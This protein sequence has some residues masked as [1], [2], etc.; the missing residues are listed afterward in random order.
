MGE[1]LW[2]IPQVLPALPQLLPIK[3]EV[4]G[5]PEHLFKEKPGFFQVTCPAET[6]DIPEA[7]HRERSFGACETIGE[8]WACPISVHERVL[9]QICFDSLQVGKPAWIR[10]RD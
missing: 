10:R 9:N 6:L 5:I 3:A 2:E 7:T 8:C 1:R 4:I